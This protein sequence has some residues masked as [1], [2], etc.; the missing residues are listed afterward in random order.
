MDNHEQIARGL[1]D[2]A[3]HIELL[4]ALREL[5]DFSCLDVDYRYAKRSKAAFDAAA[6]LL[7]RLEPT[8]PGLKINENTEND[9]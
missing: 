6:K 3:D 9:Y 2:F 4:N 8:T 7:N 1:E 5:H